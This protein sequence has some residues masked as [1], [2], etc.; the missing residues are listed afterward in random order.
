MPSVLLMACHSKFTTIQLLWLNDSS[1]PQKKKFICWH[2]IPNEM[3]F[4]GAAFGVCLGHVR[5]ALRNEISSL[6]KHA[7]RELP[8]PSARWE[9]HYGEPGSKAFTRHQTCQH[10]ILDFPSLQKVR[11]KCLLFKPIRIYYS[12]FVTISEDINILAICMPW[13]N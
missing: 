10:F 1:P 2:L 6:I 12:I 4:G 7:I 9:G 13:I 8:C 5:G 3:V 11:N